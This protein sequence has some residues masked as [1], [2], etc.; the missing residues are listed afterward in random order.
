VTDIEVWLC[1]AIGILV[2]GLAASLWEVQS[3]HSRLMR[4][5]VVVHTLREQ[6]REERRTLI[7]TRDAMMC[8][9]CAISERSDELEELAHAMA[10]LAPLQELRDDHSEFD[11]LRDGPP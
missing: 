10:I 3:L 1:A 6:L 9:L 5:W 2:G 4:A 7:A 8:K 11:R